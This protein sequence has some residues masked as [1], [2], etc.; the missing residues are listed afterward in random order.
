M[1]DT[2]P[3]ARR[4]Q[5]ELFRALTPGARVLMATRMFATAQKLATTGIDAA[6]GKETRERLLL[7]FYSRDL[8][9]H[10]LEQVRRRLAR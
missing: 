7:R 5:R 3:E 8:P 9:R 6:N 2:S 10:T 4:V 1:S